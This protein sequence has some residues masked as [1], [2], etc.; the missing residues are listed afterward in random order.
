LES[1]SPEAGTNSG[2]EESAPNDAALRRA[3]TPYQ[4]SGTARGLFQIATSFGGLFATCALMYVLYGISFWLVL[5]PAPLAA[6][7]LVRVFIIQH[8]CG[9]N[10]FFGSRLANTVTGFACSMITVT[11]FLSW[12]R[13]HAAHHGIW[14]DLDRRESG[15]D[16]YS[17]LL[18]LKEYQALSSWGRRWY[19]LSRHPI[20]ANLVL[21][22]LIF[23]F[24]YRLPFD[25]PRSWRLER[26][27]VHLTTLA[28]AGIVVGLSFAVGFKAVLAV[29]LPVIVLATFMGVWLFSIQHR[30]E[31]V[32]WARHDRWSATSAALEGTTFLRLPAILQWFTGNIGFHHVHHLNPRVPNY[33]L[34]ACHTALSQQ[35]TAPEMTLGQ[36]FSALRY[37]LWD[38]ERG[39]MLTAAG[40][41]KLTTE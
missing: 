17:S 14:N 7:F 37:I 11:P 5:I 21:P 40:A 18:T 22:P 3:T 31:Y 38:E 28:L 1:E 19:R 29:Q 30:G 2:R 8:D 4:R 25:M 23:L 10:S 12:R 15:A 16:I 9:H 41:R 34:Q 26:V 33:R 32:R 36:G 39:A 13:Q 24:L 6:A 35:H 27:F 20:F